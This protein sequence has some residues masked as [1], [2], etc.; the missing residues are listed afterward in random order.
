[1]MEDDEEGG[2][3]KPY[4]SLESCSP[5]SRLKTKENVKIKSCF[6]YASLK[7]IARR[8]NDANPDDPIPMHRSREELH[9]AIRSK[10]HHCTDER[11]WLRA[12]WLSEQDQKVLV[13]DFKPPIPEGKYTWLSTSDIERVLDQYEKVFE[14]FTNMGVWPVDFQTIAPRE[15]YP[16][17]IPTR[18]GGLVLNLDTHDQPGSHWVAL[19]LDTDKNIVEYFDSFGDQPPQEVHDWVKTLSRRQKWKLRVN[20]RVHQLR[21]SECGVYAIHFIVRRLSG[22]SYNKVINNIIRDDRMNGFRKKYF[23]PREKYDN[24]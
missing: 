14:D 17:R 5:I 6:P 1:M 21:N 18:Y 13:E 9:E 3:R 7:R 2:G 15:F 4:A 22:E 12:S 20:H 23:D 19:F 8:Y 16:L 24:K 10:L 11:C